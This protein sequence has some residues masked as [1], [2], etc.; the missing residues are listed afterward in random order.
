[1]KKIPRVLLALVLGIPIMIVVYA[2]EFIHHK[3][4]GTILQWCRIAENWIAN[5]AR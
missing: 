5:I 4:S 1:M 3:I 2:W